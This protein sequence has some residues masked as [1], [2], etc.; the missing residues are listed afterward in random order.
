VLVDGGVEEKLP[1]PTGYGASMSADGQSIACEPIRSWF[2][3]WKRY[4]GGSTSR[5]WLERFSESSVTPVPR[6]NSNDFNPVLVGDR[7]RRHAVVLQTRG[8]RQAHRHAHLGRSGGDKRFAR[9][10]GWRLCAVP[11]SGIY[12]PLT[13]E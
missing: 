7:V 6:T 9:A 11:S 13:G 12:S 10:D 8:R 5:I 3:M 2:A 1:L 4:R